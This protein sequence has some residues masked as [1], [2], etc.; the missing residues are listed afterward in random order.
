MPGGGLVSRWWRH[1]ALAGLV[2]GLLAAP[3]LD[4]PPGTASLLAI[5]VPVLVI[6]S[7]GRAAGRPGKAALLGLVAGLGAL[8]GLL[9]GDLRL[10]SLEGSALVAEPGVSAE[11]EGVVVSTPRSSK[12]RLRFTLE[13]SAGRVLV[14]SP[15]LTG[16]P[17]PS[18][19]ARVAAGGR[20]SEPEPFRVD[21][22]ARLG[23]ELELRA[24][25]LHVLPGGRSG[26][27]GFLDRSRSRAERAI[28]AGLSPEQAALARGFVLGQDGRIDEATREEFRRS[29]LAHL[30]AVSGQN[31]MLLAILA[32][33]LLSLLG[34]GQRTRLA[35][36]FSS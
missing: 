28:S 6:V 1:V 22:L 35:W 4:A 26:L 5:G 9:A 36:R 27:D 18:V 3:G 10:R 13:T 16:G 20:L 12:G 21:E 7:R 31:V 30:L 23:A 33:V 29:G 32:G 24:G 11:V 8:V 25:R 14:A 34:V 15:A 2:A 19:G 17:E